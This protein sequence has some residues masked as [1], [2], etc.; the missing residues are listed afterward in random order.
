MTTTTILAQ[1]RGLDN[2]GKA[3]YK[4]VIANLEK[5]GI[6]VRSFITYLCDDIC[7]YEDISKFIESMKKLLN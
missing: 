7:E 1:K 4:V 3:F 6:T 2:D 5:V